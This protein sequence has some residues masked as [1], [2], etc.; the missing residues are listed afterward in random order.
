MVA[1]EK[2]FLGD[3][4]ILFVSAKVDKIIRFAKVVEH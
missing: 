3:I 4:I 2:E 1:N